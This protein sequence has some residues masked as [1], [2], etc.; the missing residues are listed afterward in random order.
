[1]LTVILAEPGAVEQLIVFLRQLTPPVRVF[2]YPIMKSILDGLLLL[3]SKGGLFRIENAALLTV[4][5]CLGIV[6][7]YIAEIKRVLQNLV[8]ICSLCTVGHPGVDISV[9]DAAL[10]GDI[11]LGGKFRIID[12]NIVAQVRRRVQKLVHELLN[13]LFADPRRA[14]AYLDF[15]GVQVFRLGGCQCVYIDLEFGVS[16]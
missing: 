16:R 10:A 9:A 7:S 5:I 3:L 15:G 1:M 14:E 8:G 12:L 2:P 13:V 6:D 11:P 4:R